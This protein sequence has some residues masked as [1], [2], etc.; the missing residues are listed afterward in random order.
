M[1]IITS[2]LSTHV[3]D[4]FGELVKAF[5]RCLNIAVICRGRDGGVLV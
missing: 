4:L 3:R 1:I 5:E 2:H